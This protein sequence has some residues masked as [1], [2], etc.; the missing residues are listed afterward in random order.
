MSNLGFT[1][2]RETEGSELKLRNY[3]E[4][5]D[6]LM[7]L[8]R[9]DTYVTGGCRG[10]D[11]L[12]GEYLRLKFPP[13]VAYHVVVIPANKSQVDPWWEKFDVGT[14]DLVYMPD[15]TDY[16]DR[17]EAIVQRV[18]QVFYCADYPEQHVKSKRSGT[19]MTK[20]IAESQGVPVSGIIL[21]KET[22]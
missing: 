16:R 14:V 2:T 11:A 20:R 3:L 6:M 5:A 18:E 15:G 19:W 4:S 13:P 17:N 8:R 9:F 21:N 12:V 7:Y 1:G 22:T 10:W